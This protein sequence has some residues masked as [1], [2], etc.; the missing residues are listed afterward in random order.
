MSLIADEADVGMG[1]IYHYFQ[2]KETLVNVLYKELKVKVNHAMLANYSRESPIRERFFQI[3]RNLFHHYL[4]NPLLFQFLEQYAYSPT[5]TMETRHIGYKLWE[6]PIRLFHD[7]KQ[8]QVIKDLPIDLMMNIASSPVISLV[9]SHI[10]GQIA[11]DNAMV[12]AAITA[13]WDAI[14]I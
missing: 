7:A 8:Q 14:K 11:L 12:E 3:W 9:R 13:C 6:E 5:I 4:E 2:N 1:T 10:A